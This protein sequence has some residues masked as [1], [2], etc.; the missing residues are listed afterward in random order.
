MNSSEIRAWN[1]EADLSKIAKHYP[2]RTIWSG[3]KRGYINCLQYHTSDFD[4]L[5]QEGMQGHK[6][7]LVSP[8]ET[9]AIFDNF[10]YLDRKK[11]IV[12]SV[13]PQYI[14]PSKN[15]EKYDPAI[16]N[17]FFDNERYLRFFNKYNQKNC[18]L[19][20][21]TNFTITKCECTVFYMPS[22]F[23]IHFFSH[24]KNIFINF[25]K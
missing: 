20:C 12:L 23:Y 21:L 22:S 1:V 10:I 11:E 6:I 18:E 2:K 8:D 4:Y 7:V 14:M 19:E 25:Q 9:P 15:I 3:A 13:T 5:C 16:R 17:C 24:Q